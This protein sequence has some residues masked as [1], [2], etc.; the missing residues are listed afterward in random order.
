MKKGIQIYLIGKRI[1]RVKL[2]LFISFGITTGTLIGIIINSLIIA[3][4]SGIFFGLG[5]ILI[6]RE[7]YWIISNNGVYT[8]LNFG[9]IKYLIVMIKYIIL[10]DD[11]S[12]LVFMNYREISYVNLL[13]KADGLG[14]QI[15][16]KD[17]S[18]V[19]IVILEEFFNQDLI[20]SIYYIKRKGI[21]I[22]NLSI[23]ENIRF[24]IYKD[25]LVIQK[26][27]L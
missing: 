26:K 21:K 14:I 27:K 4:I 11:T 10:G 20:N 9:I 8:P 19:S 7:Y 13:L 18:L 25:E 3:I 17:N 5:S 24:D 23:L 22:K 15:I 2:I 16:C 1:Q 12:N 6:T